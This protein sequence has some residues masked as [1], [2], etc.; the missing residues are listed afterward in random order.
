VVLGL[1]A[2]YSASFVIGYVEFG[3][4]SYFVT[5]QAL[6]ALVGFL[7]LGAFMMMDYHRL[8]PLSVPILL[9]TLGALMAVFIPGLGLERHGASRWLAL[10]PLPPVQPSEFA[11][12]SLVIYIAAWA[13]AK[14]ES[15]RRFSLGLLPFVI[16]VGVVGGL[17]MREPDLGTTVVI[18]LIAG[19]IFFLSGAPLSHVA[20][21][22]LGGSLV[23]MALVFTSGYRMDRIL[24]FL[25]PDA[26]PQGAGFHIRQLLIALG[27]GG[28]GGLGFGASRQKFGYIPNSH[29]D[30]IF[31]IIGEEMGLIGALLILGLLAFLVQ[32]GLRLVRRSP[33]PFGALLALG[34][35]CWIAYQALINIGGITR[36]IPLTGIPLPFISYGG[37]ALAALLAGV[38]VLL[39]VSRYAGEAYIGRES[40]EQELRR[41]WA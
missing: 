33:D 30:G 4:G 11:K 21:L 12:L 34:V 23:T 36:S 1:L 15:I 18:L 22:A 26:D 38:G 14:G 5:R 32:R 29:T 39:S 28:I 17:V 9:L 24:A 40:Q 3:D 37:S 31:A 25:S 20:L 10:G 13:S 35:T 2:V 16:I 19:T 6:W 27:S 8:R 7:L 41:V